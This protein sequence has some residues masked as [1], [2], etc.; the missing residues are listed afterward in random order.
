L[1]PAERPDNALRRQQALTEDAENGKLCNRTV[2]STPR[3]EITLVS[4][5]T[6]KAIIVLKELIFLLELIPK[7]VSRLKYFLSAS[8]LPRS[9]ACETE[10]DGEQ[11]HPAQTLLYKP[12]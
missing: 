4:L 11:P 3:S 9:R 7:L 5:D 8:L 12:L 10:H 1:S 6:I 2:D